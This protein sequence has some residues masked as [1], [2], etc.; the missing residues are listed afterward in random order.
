[1]HSV[2]HM[3]MTSVSWLFVTS[4]VSF[5]VEYIT[6]IIISHGSQDARRSCWIRKRA[7]REGDQEFLSSMQ[8]ELK[9]KLRWSQKVFS[10]MLESQWKHLWDACDE[11]Q[12]LKEER[13][14]DRYDWSPFQAASYPTI[15]IRTD[16]GRTR[17][18][19]QVVSWR[20]SWPRWVKTAPRALACVRIKFQCCGR[21]LTLFWYLKTHP[22]ARS[23]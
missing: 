11:D 23:D 20:P 9:K 17:F 22:S 12:K 16:E 10:K 8:K 6:P 2:I 4:Y 5:C 14:R 21:C 19:V 15:R 7:F 1:M 18:Q 3:E 13:E